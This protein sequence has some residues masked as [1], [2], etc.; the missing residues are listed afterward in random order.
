MKNKHM[1]HFNKKLTFG[2]LSILL[3][4]NAFAQTANND[5]AFPD[6]WLGTYNGQMYML[7]P[8][9]GI[10]DSVSVKLELL[11]TDMPKQWVYRMTYKGNKKYGKIIKDY[12]IV[13]PDSLA[14]GTYLLDEKDGII[15]EQTLIGNTFYSNFSVGNSYLNSIMRK[16]GDIIHFEI[17]QSNVKESL[18]TKNRA[19][20]GQ[21]V[22]E[23]KSY[24]IFTT[25]KAKLLKEK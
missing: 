9:V 11:S 12:L 1:K 19:N 5:E 17:F 3:S 6:S 10:T 25:Q 13:K 21:I 24:P 4:L 14:E 18:I 7:K 23:V 8:G 15:I 16:T 2:L 20:E 22:F